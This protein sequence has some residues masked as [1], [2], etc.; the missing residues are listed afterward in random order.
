MRLLLSISVYLFVE[1]EAIRVI[2]YCT[3]VSMWVSEG[4]R[5]LI[6]LYID[7]I[8]A[9]YAQPIAV[10][11]ARPRQISYAVTQFYL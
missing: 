11:V 8:C 7:P 6:L 3:V 1:E 5:Q 2:R 10:A 9:R 4:T